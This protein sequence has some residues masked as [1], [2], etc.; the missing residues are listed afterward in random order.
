MSEPCTPGDRQ[1]A[2]GH[3][4]TKVRLRSAI[5]GSG[6]LRA[7]S[8]THNELLAQCD[9]VCHASRQAVC[10][11]LVK[12]LAAPQIGVA[13]A[14]GHYGARVVPHDAACGAAAGALPIWPSAHAAISAL[15]GPAPLGNNN[16]AQLPRALTHDAAPEW[17]APL[18]AS[19]DGAPVQVVELPVRQ[20]S[21]SVLLRAAGMHPPC[22]C[23]A[24]VRLPR[25]QHARLVACWPLT[26]RCRA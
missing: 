24:L 1:Q 9:C 13:G 19:L 12:A 16:T 7:C 10:A 23:A 26:C 15:R 21:R 17:E 6:E 18:W 14:A 8:S 2:C 3:A 4:R 22:S 11:P 20:G 25:G 5:Q